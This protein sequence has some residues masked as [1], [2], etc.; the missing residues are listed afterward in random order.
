[1]RP[2]QESLES[3]EPYWTPSTLWNQPLEGMR[4]QPVSRLLMRLLLLM[5]RK[6]VLSIVGEDNIGIDKDPYILVAN[7]S[8]YAEA[9]LMGALLAFLR[10]GKRVRFLADWNFALIPPVALIYYCGRCILL[11][12]KPTKPKFLGAFKPLFVRGVSGFEQAKEAL[13]NGEC[14]GVFPEGTANRDPHHLLKGH[15]GAA[16]LSLETGAALVP[17]GLYYPGFTGVRRIEESAAAEIR[18]GAPMKPGQTMTRA[19][20]SDV[21]EW[22]QEMMRAISTL[23]GKKLSSVRRLKRGENA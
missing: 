21:R 16:R 17:T 13:A 12:Q 22:H 19:P 23:S 14:V 9:A 18:F 3:G 20:V 1:M 6:H 5:R 4:G 8:Q 7:H 2:L 10:R 15:S 11:D